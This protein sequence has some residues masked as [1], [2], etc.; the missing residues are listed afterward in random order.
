MQRLAFAGHLELPEEIVLGSVSICLFGQTE[1]VLENYRKILEYEEDHI[2]VQ[3]KIREKGMFAKRVQIRGRQ[4][5]IAYY[6]EYEM[7]INGW[8]DG[9]EFL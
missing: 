9:I 6:T 3:T 8:I 2:C 4:L 5:K 1:L 7:Q